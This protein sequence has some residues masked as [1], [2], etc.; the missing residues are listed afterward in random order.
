M[1]TSGWAAGHTWPWRPAGYTAARWGAAVWTPASWSSLG[2]WFGWGQTPYY[3]Y[4]YGNTVVYQNGNVCLDG[5]PV[6]SADQYYQSAMELAN[7]A[8]SASAN[9]DSSQ[10]LPLGVFGMMRTD[11]KT[12]DMI[13]QLAVD[14]TGTIR[15]NYTNTTVNDTQPVHGSVDK[16]SQRAVWTV[17]DNKA[18]TVETG[19]YNLTKDQSTALVHLSPT[20]ADTYTL[21][22]M[23]QPQDGGP[24]GGATGGGGN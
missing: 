15:G 24:T 3:N 21:I 12:A 13:F 10:W 20:K 22:R 8:P 18:V 5:Q 6:C 23:K 17:G 19:V 1:F 11:Q 4:D 16:Q 14:K 2:T 7:A 9:D